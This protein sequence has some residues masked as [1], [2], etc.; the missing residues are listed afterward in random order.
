M[1]SH[2]EQLLNA[3]VGGKIKL[4]TPDK[5]MELIENISTLSSINFNKWSYF[6][7]Q[8]LKNLTANND[9]KIIINWS[10]ST[11]NTKVTNAMYDMDLTT[12]K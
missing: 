12:Q 2:S 10:I 6:F 7:Y 3:S 9:N 8:K 1:Q 5:A 11:V 4:K